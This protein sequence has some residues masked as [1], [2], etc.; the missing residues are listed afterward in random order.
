LPQ[1]PQLFESV[2][3]GTGY[4]AQVR[5][6]LPPEQYWPGP[7]AWPQAPQF[8]VSVTRQGKLPPP[9]S[10]SPSEQLDAGK[11]QSTG[12]PN[13]CPTGLAPRGQALSQTPAYGPG[14]Q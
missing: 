12:V 2:S 3:T 6:Q 8:M 14:M 9:Q 1:F 4:P 7:Q 13:D 5:L 10:A 11:A